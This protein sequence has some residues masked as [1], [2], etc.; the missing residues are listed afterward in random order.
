M[1]I[2]NGRHT[3][4]Q[5][6][7]LDAFLRDQTPKTIESTALDEMEAACSVAA[8]RDHSEEMGICE[9]MQLVEGE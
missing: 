8:K 7:Q 6:H 5:P 4:T 9:K 1:F 2:V 3:T